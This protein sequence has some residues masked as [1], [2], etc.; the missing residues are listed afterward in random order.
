MLWRFLLGWTIA[1]GAACC[2]QRAHAQDT[3]RVRIPLPTDSL[4]KE[5]VRDTTKSKKFDPNITRFADLQQEMEGMLEQHLAKTRILNLNLD[6]Y[7]Q[8]VARLAEQFR[9][10]KNVVA[11]RDSAL[12][13]LVRIR[14]F[15]EASMRQVKDT[16]F[17]WLPYWRALTAVYA[18]YGEMRA[19]DK[20]DAA[21][22]AF[23][24]RHRELYALLDGITVRLRDLHNETEF[25]LNS[26][27]N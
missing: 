8:D 13:A 16:H 12:R 25:L 6:R 27:L 5:L 19:L 20:A 23:I 26:K 10:P 17:E 24:L 1:M 18:R 14:R 22:R 3:A 4:D 15:Y 21:T 2:L 11:Q 9:Y 7:T